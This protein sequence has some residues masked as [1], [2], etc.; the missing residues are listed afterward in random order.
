MNE[1]PI[2]RMIGEIVICAKTNGKTFSARLVDIRDNELWFE[3]RSGT[4]MMNKR[5][6]ISSICVYIQPSEE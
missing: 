4:L 2:M 5:E 1:D 3:N 6:V